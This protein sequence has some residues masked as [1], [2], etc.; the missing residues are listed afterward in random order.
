MQSEAR[1]LVRHPE[2]CWISERRV[3]Q[4]LLAEFVV[5]TFSWILIVICGKKCESGELG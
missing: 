4:F 5:T 3:H 1:L 2:R